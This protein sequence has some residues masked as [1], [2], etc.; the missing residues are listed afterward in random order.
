M[1]GI[2]IIIIIIGRLI[3]LVFLPVNRGQSQNQRPEK[4]GEV[5]PQKIFEKF[6][7]KPLV[8]VHIWSEHLK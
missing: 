2:I 8:L 1:Y 7:L 5:C 6:N 4:K 3:S